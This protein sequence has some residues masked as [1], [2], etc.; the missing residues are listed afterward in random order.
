MKTKLHELAKLGQSIWYDNISR[1]IIEN[2]ELQKLLDQGVLGVTSNPTIFEK[3]FAGSADYDSAIQ[4]LV[5][6]DKSVEQIY[7]ALVLEDICRAAASLRP[8]YERT[9]GKD[10]YIS[11]EVSPTLAHDTQGTLR[12][13]RRYWQMLGQ[14]NIMIKVPATPAGIP[15]IAQLISEGINVNITLIFSLESYAAVMEAYLSG[16]E[17][18][19]DAGSPIN[20]IASVASFFVSRVDSAIDPQLAKLGATALQGQAAI[21]NAKLAYA[22]FQQLFSGP[23]WEK[24][25]AL[26]A[27][28]QRPLWASTGVKNPAY[29]DTLYAD[30]LIGADTVN[31][32]PPATLA[33]MLDHVTLAETLTQDVA[34]AQKLITQLGQTGIDM[35]QVTQQLQDEGVASFAK[36]FETLLAA[37][38]N[39]RDQ[40]QAKL[41]LA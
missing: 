40:L 22:R 30:A 12:E 39:K 25:A 37:L 1:K 35:A 28:V 17:Q 2:G 5:A 32:V 41:E 21:A 34:A 4:E 18:R 16:L 13:A 15:A 23:R 36:S 24:L 38:A 11:L 7:E 10:G 8:I 14:P 3:A 20:M 29:P 6:A 26:G 31:T 27:Q 9:E 19:A 33:A